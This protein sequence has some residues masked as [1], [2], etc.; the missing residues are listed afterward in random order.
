MTE[1][2]CPFCPPDP[3]RVFYPSELVV[4]L[5]DAH[6][7]SAGHALLVTRRHVAAWWDATAQEQLALLAALAVARE[8]ILR[9]HRP[10]GFNVG[11]NAGAAAGQTVSHLHLR[12]GVH[13]TAT[14]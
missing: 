2:A 9:R 11:F 14:A 13:P 10:D 4:G 6:P 3:A 7:V 1:A 12:W 8:E 5:W